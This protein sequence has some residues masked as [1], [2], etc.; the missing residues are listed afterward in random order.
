VTKDE[1][2]AHVIS[3]IP[4]SIPIQQVSSHTLIKYILSVVSRS[5]HRI[6][7]RKCNLKFLQLKSTSAI[8]TR[9][10]TKV[11]KQNL[12]CRLVVLGI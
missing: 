4:L 6:E 7:L 11:F 9:F 1:P 2:K 8:F 10:L 3:S 12:R 5:V